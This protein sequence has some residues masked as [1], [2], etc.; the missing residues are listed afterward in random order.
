MINCST[1]CCCWESAEK[2]KHEERIPGE[3][4]GINSSGLGVN[5]E[6]VIE[7]RNIMISIAVVN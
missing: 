3:S 1:Q 6:G 7:E 2:V 4:I 5:N